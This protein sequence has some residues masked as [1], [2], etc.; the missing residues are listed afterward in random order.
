MASAS[1][2]VA[3]P[4]A[5]AQAWVTDTR[6]PGIGLAGVRPRSRGA[7]TMSLS[8]PIEV[9]RAVIAT[10]RRTAVITSAPASIATTPTTRPSSRHGKG[11]VSRISAPSRSVGPGRPPWP[12][13]AA[14]SDVDDL[15][16]VL[17]QVLDQAVAPVRDLSPD[18]GHQ[19]VQGDRR[20]DEPALRI[21][22]DD[23]G[24]PAAGSEHPFETAIIQ[25]G[26]ALECLD[27]LDD[28]AP[29]HDIAEQLGDPGVDLVVRLV[30]QARS[31][32][33]RVRRERGRC[34][35]A[36]CVIPPGPR[37]RSMPDRPPQRPRGRHRATL[38]AS[39]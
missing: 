24:R 30:G 38:P 10:P 23:G 1:P 15:V 11:W 21:A 8:D 18:P 39:R 25:A 32:F 34:H 19:G 9:W 16:E 17:D 29:D 27:H 3:P 35:A 13:P 4:I 28:A 2:S 6:P 7:S 12:T 22:P 33:L 5:T 37:S 20:D 36:S 14:G 26:G 31:I